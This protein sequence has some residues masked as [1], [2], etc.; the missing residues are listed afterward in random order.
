[1]CPHSFITSLLPSDR[2]PLRVHTCR[3]VVKRGAS[4]EI[5]PRH[6]MCARQL[7]EEVMTKRA[8]GGWTAGTLQG[9]GVGSRGRRLFYIR[10]LKHKTWWKCLGDFCPTTHRVISRF[11]S[12]DE[13][14]TQ[15]SEHIGCVHESIFKP[16]SEL[17]NVF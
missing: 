17:Q 14:K 10:Q 1:M 6:E 12:P 13:V 4:A 11:S 3:P 16:L 2:L 15:E 9:L 8:L 5:K 7:C